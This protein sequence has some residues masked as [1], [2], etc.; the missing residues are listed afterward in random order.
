MLKQISILT[1]LHFHGVQHKVKAFT[2][3]QL[4][5]RNEVTVSSNQNNLINLALLRQRRYIHAD[6][7]IDAF[8]SNG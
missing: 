7:H 3:C 5:G 6:F 4:C 2:S 8:L 1:N